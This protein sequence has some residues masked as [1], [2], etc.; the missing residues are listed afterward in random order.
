MWGVAIT[1]A[2]LSLFSLPLTLLLLAVAGGA[3]VVSA[4]FRGTMLQRSTPDE[5]RGRV[6]AVNLIVVTGGG[7]SAMRR[8]GWWPVSPERRHP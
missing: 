8:P 5:L 1:G 3:G 2:G 6:S 4:I 7:A